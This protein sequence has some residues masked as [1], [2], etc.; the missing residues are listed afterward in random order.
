MSSIRVRSALVVCVRTNSKRESLMVTSWSAM[1]FFDIFWLKSAGIVFVLSGFAREAAEREKKALI[2]RG[3]FVVAGGVNG[4][5]FWG[6]Q[7]KLACCT[8]C[9]VAK[10]RICGLLREI[11]RFSICTIQS[12]TQQTWRLL[13]APPHV[14]CQNGKRCA[15]DLRCKSSYK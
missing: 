5:C 10:G 9:L 15:F 12:I 8:W 2:G 14:K 1:A 11:R 6:Y 7:W 13:V 4:N 3:F